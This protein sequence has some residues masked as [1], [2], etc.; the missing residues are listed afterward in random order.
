MSLQIPQG[1]QNNLVY[2][3]IFL[4]YSLLEWYLGR[5]KKVQSSSLIELVVAGFV[6]ILGTILIF[7]EK[8]WPKKL[9]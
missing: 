5:T 2:W 4:A 6:V 1:C 7:K 9:G 3:G 8:I